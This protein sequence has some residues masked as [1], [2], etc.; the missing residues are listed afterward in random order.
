MNSLQ[1]ICIGAIGAG[2]LALSGCGKEEYRTGI[3]IQEGG[4]VVNNRLVKSDEALLGH[5]TS[6]ETVKLGEPTYILRVKADDGIYTISVLPSWKDLEALEMVIKKGTK[7]KFPLYIPLEP[8][9]ASFDE[10]DKIGYVKSSYL[11]VL[12]E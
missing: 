10:E 3:V 11:E 2:A 6:S 12:K 7:V 5:I 1:K 8:E 9:I 4:S